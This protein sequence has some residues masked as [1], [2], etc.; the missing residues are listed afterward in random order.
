VNNDHQLKT[1]VLAE[2]AY[3]PSI[4][5]DHIGV[6]AKDGTVTL[7]GHVDTYWQKMAAETA[8]GRVK[9]VKAL[10]EENEVRLP[11][12]IRHGDDEIAS[13]A[14]NRMA[15]D[16]SMPRDAVKVKVE[17][18]HVTLTGSVGQ[19]YQKDAAAWDIRPLMGVTGV[20]NQITVKPQPDSLTISDDIRHAL[21]RSWMFDENIKVSA[22]G[23]KVHLTGKVDNWHNR[24]LASAT[25][26]AAPGTTSVSNDIS[27]G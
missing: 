7:S 18:G 23:G 24:E 16:V 25:A 4:S 17:K 11:L 10:A 19:Y 26:W 20:T 14:L 22:T 15:W 6:T 5:A 1:D 27:V 12:H 3:E 2:L 8:A 9:G 21:H 13:A